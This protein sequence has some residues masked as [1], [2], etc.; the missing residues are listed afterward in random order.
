[1][2]EVQTN[3]D[4]MLTLET[5]N[6]EASNGDVYEVVVP[7]DGW[8]GL[9]EA[10]EMAEYQRQYVRQLVLDGK[11]EAVKISRKGFNK[12]FVNPESIEEYKSR[13][14]TR[15]GLRRFILRMELES[16]GAAREALDATGIEYSLELQYK[17]KS[18]TEDED[19]S[20]AEVEAE[21]E[22]FLS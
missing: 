15:G 7:P 5:K 14:V 2:L 20:E 4:S 12:W 13:T 16:E 18:E 21:A 22:D 10:A 6:L 17:P 9:S 3:Q 19:E 1:M 8:L 11:L